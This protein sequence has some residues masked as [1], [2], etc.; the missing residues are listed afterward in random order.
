MPWA[1][2]CAATTTNLNPAGTL[3]GRCNRVAG[4]P[5][6]LPK[7]QQRYYNGVESLTLPNGRIITPAVNTFMKW[8]PDAW[9][10]PTVTM[11]NGK[12]FVDQY[13][14]GS[15]PL[16]IGY[17]RTPGIQNVNLSVIKRFPVRERMGFDLHVNATNAFNHTNHQITINTD[18][19]NQVNAITTAGST[20]GRNGNLQFGSYGLTALE[21]RQLTIQANFTF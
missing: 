20:A 7:S 15:T 11:S 12:V 6:E 13:T 2:T 17:L 19:T 21:P 4:E 10:E 1:P 5:I 3:N 8:N 9:S 18:N 14:L 16:T